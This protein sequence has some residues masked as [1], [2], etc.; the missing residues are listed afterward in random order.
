MVNK[1]KYFV[2][3]TKGSARTISKHMKKSTAEKKVRS[4]KKR[5]ISAKIGSC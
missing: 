1:C 3:N 5:G 2:Y 4:L